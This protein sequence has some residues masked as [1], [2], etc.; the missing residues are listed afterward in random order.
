MS[1]HIWAL[2]RDQEALERVLVILGGGYTLFITVVTYK[3]NLERH[4][5]VHV[6]KT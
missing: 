4:V 5:H 1:I 6:E 3:K 2:F